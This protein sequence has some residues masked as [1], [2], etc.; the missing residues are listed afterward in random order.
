M[1]EKPAI[2]ITDKKISNVQEF[3]PI[4]EKLAAAGKKDVVLIAIK[5]KW[6]V[7]YD[8]YMKAP[9]GKQQLGEA[10][11]VKIQDGLYVGNLWGQEHYGND[12]KIYTDKMSLL[13]ALH[14]AFSF[15]EDFGLEIKSPKIGSGL[16][17]L[18]WDRDTV[19]L[20]E[21]IMTLYPNVKVKVFTI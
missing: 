11:F 4:L 20:F 19:P 18:D 5:T 14:K 16:G 13:K 8:E 15:A 12:G 1:S 2:V 9:T 6:P 17:G 3:L 7:V 21:L 10:Q